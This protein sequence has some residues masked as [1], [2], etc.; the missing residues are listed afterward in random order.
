MLQFYGY[1]KC[2]TCIKAKKWLEKNQIKYKDIDITENPP[3]FTILKK[4][5][6][7]NDYPINKFFNTSGVKYREMKMKD[8]IKSLSDNE[9]LKIL[10]RE[11]KLIKRPFVF[12]EDQLTLGFKEEVFKEAWG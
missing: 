7:N 8:K 5:F 1:N 10:S 12:K 4:L 2:S 6:Q 9:L 11:G 3:S